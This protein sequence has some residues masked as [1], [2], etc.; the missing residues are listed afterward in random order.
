[1]TAEDRPE[2]SVCVFFPGGYYI[3]ECRYVPAREAVET[4]KRMTQN[5]AARAGL[6]TRVIVTD[7]GDCINMEWRFGEGYTYPPELRGWPHAEN[8]LRTKSYKPDREGL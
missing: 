4:F 5:V 8:E 2:F 1:M 6:T 3:H 7:G